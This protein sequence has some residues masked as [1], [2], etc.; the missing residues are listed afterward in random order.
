M[1]TLFINTGIVLGVAAGGQTQIYSDAQ[2]IEHL[3]ERVRI[4]VCEDFAE[5]HDLALAA[6]ACQAVNIL[7]DGF[8]RCFVV[9]V[10]ASAHLAEKAEVSQDAQVVLLDAVL[11]YANEADLFVQ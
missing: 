3:H 10:G 9:L 6:N 5:L 4:A 11:W 7:S 2:I 8:D 1:E